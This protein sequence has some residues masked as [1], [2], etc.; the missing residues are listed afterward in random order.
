MLA[1]NSGNLSSA[2]SGLESVADTLA[3]A[4][5]Y[6]SVN[7]LKSSLEQAS[8]LL[9]NLNEGRGTAGQLMTNDSLYTNLS[10]TLGSLNLLL[11]DMRTNPK[12][13]VHFSLFGRKE[14]QE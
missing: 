10:N 1:D 14:R 7:N 13:Y 6:S 9:N 11:A 2:L 3:A 4:D 8:L 12:K 5:L